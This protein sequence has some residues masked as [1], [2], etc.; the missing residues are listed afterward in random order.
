[1]KF[2]SINSLPVLNTIFSKLDCFYFEKPKEKHMLDS[3]I[4]KFVIS[5]EQLNTEQLNLKLEF[6]QNCKQFSTYIPLSFF[7]E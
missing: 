1:M 4:W 6:K 5:R 7:I 2:L 3:F